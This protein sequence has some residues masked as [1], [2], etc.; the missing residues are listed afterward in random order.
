MKRIAIIFSADAEPVAA[1]TKLLNRHQINIKEFNFNKFGD[2]AC[3][4]LVVDH[5]DRALSVLTAEGYKAVSSDIVLISAR[6]HVGEL[7]EISRVLMDKGVG[8]RSLN[9]IDVHSG[10][11]IIAIVTTDNAMVRTIFADLVVN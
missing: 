7:A 10:T 2:N 9:L 8:I 3:L 6:D 4:S 5:Y 11:G 1:V